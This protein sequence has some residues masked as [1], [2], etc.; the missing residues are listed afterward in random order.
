MF[1]DYQKTI[2]YMFEIMT[3]FILSLEIINY[4]NALVNNYIYIYK[5]G[6]A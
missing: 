1:T 5:L 6:D 2:E 3:E 4:V